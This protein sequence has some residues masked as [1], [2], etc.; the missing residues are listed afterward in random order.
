MENNSLTNVRKFD[1]DN[2]DNDI[3]NEPNIID[4]SSYYEF[5]NVMCL[6]NK[7]TNSFSILSTNA[8]SINGKIDQLRIFIER[9]KTLGH[10]FSAI[11]IQEA[12]LTDD[13]DTS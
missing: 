6:L 12:W 5:N 11:C 9:L 8:Q 1:L 13:S 10:E 7:T 2:T 4:H 3:H